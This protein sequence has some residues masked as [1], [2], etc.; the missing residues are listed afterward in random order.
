M[1]TSTK[2]IFSISI[3][4]FLFLFSG[5]TQVQAQTL[6]AGD[7]SIIGF[8][9]GLSNR[10]GFAFVPWIDLPIGTVIK[11]TDN[12]FNA[13]ASALNTGNYR[14]QEQTATW[15]ATTAVT[16][17]TIVTIEGNGSS[18]TFVANTGS[19]AVTN[20]DGTPT[21]ALNLGNGGDQ[22]FAFQ[23]GAYI[24]SNSL[25]GTMA[26]NTVMLYGVG[27]QGIGTTAGWLTTGT[28]GSATSYL[29]T[30]LS[31]Y[32]LFFASNAVAGEYTGTRTGQTVA[33]F[34]AAVNNVA[35]WTTYTTG[36]VTTYNTTAFPTTAAP[37]ITTQPSGSTVCA[38]A[39]TTFSVVATNATGYQWQE[40]SGSGFANIT[41]GGIYS[42]ATTATLTLTGVTAGMSGYAYRVV[43][44]G[45]S[46]VNSNSVTLTVN[47]PGTWLGTSNSAWSNTANWSCA[48]L[49]TS[50]TNVVIPSGTPNSPIIDITSA[51]ANNLTINSG[52]TLSFTGTTNALAIYG[53]L[54]NNG[55]F[56]TTSGKV[57]FAGASQTIPAMTYQNLQI[58]SAGSSKTLAGATTVNG[59]LTLTNGFLLLGNNNLTLGNTAAISGG[60]NINSF[61]VVNGTGSL[62]QQNI[63]SGGRAGTILFPLGTSTASFTPI[64]ISNSTGVADVF[65]ARVIDHVYTAYNASDVPTGSQITSKVVDRTWTIKEGTPGGSN[66]TVTLQWSDDEQLSGFLSNSC[67]L[68]HYT[69]GAWT[70]NGLPFTDAG[71][72]PYTI[73]RA[74]ITTFSPFGVGSPGSPLPVN[75]MS[76]DGAYASGKVNLHWTVA[77]ETNIDHY[78]V[79]RSINGDDFEKTGQP[80][81][82]RN[83]QQ[84]YKYSFTDATVAANAAYYYRLHIIGQDGGAKYSQ[85]VKINTGND[86]KATDV[87]LM[88]NPAKNN[89]ELKAI[90]AN[91]EDAVVRITDLMGRVIS[92]A[93]YPVQSGVQTISIPV[94]NLGAN[95]FYLVKVAIG[96]QAYQ[97]KV[98]V[99]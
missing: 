10:D 89:I 95:K 28:A 53:V 49:P 80:V 13:N 63:G 75:L 90:S 71:F 60:N 30:Q 23:G 52:A 2:R 65:T 25:T 7:I 88:H 43:V 96:H 16:A 64:R 70:N 41:N 3:A 29:P 19:I 21:A 40:N 57:N 91:N 27:F 48:T 11:F 68:S 47:S 38:G 72:S 15:T 37:S 93:T 87:V 46:N 74:G 51:A 92:S 77:E 44:A 14:D 50:S 79:E 9:S 83:S 59:V 66:A 22:I 42:N 6:A 81:M 84:E 39:T 17:G 98:L 18:A 94:G 82:G 5:I 78:E 85:V 55:T 86:A 1:K 99:D 35:N 20:A 76:F 4:L 97:F 73:S 26:A 61:I 12:G 54:T 32:N 34:K 62:I 31:T 45:S 33:Q 36:G 8:N 24:T 56:T 69:G 67:V 58:S